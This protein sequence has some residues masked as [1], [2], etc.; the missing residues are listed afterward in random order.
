MKD[1]TPLVSVLVTPYNQQEYIRQTLDSI[2]MQVC[3]FDFE[4][5]IGEDCSTDGT[6]EICQEYALRHPETIVLCLNE[7]NKG[8][9]NNYFD[10][11][12]QAKG[13]YIADCG[14]DDY[15]LTETK[16]QEQVDLLE[17]HPEVSMVTGNWE[18][19]LQQTGERIRPA[20]WIEADRYR[21]EQWGRAAVANYFNS[22]DM[23]RVVLAASCFRGDWAREL[24]ASHPELFRS[25]G[26]VCEDLPLT[27]GL[28]M[29][30]PIYFS[31]AN[32]LVYRV[33]QKSL[34]HSERRD[35]YVRGFAF[36]AY[37]QTLSLA[38]TLGVSLRQIKPYADAKAGD[39]ILHAFLT[40]DSAFMERLRREGLRFTLK[41][42][43]LQLGMR[44]PLLA[45]P[46]RRLYLQR[47]PRS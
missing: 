11:F 29:R 37:R 34:S 26:V 1:K 13:R 15:W 9:L 12:L 14:G 2:L 19:Y 8:L 24:Y 47:N 36:A 27:L 35:D 33:L 32:W 25:E 41:H 20:S 42:R 21:P 7:R 39:F 46:L 38:G 30:G 45:E 16:L 22:T 43:L 3:D 31:Q 18:N 6:R 40:K 44:L 5:L 10:L 23:P 4:L 28:L 17:S